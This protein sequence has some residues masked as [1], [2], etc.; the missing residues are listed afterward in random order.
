MSLREIR[1]TRSFQCTYNSPRRAKRSR[2]SA[3]SPGKYFSINFIISSGRSAKVR[4]VLI[5]WAASCQ[6]A[7]FV[8]SPPPAV[9]RSSGL[10]TAR[11]HAAHVRA[12]PYPVPSTKNLRKDPI[13]AKHSD[14]SEISSIAFG[15][16]M[17]SLTIP[18]FAI[19]SFPFQRSPAYLRR[20]QSTDQDAFLHSADLLVL[21]FHRLLSGDHA[22]ADNAPGGG[23]RKHRRRSATLL[24]TRPTHDRRGR[25][26]G[27]DRRQRH[28]QYQRFAE[29]LSR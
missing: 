26:G 21:P 5:F 18:I 29:R 28:A 8:A 24:R 1:F 12:S 27:V 11:A 14:R 2:C 19:N 25:P 7:P 9:R 10:S 16:L 22:G 15:P 13:N 4:A 3:V 17:A 23:R 6:V 20:S